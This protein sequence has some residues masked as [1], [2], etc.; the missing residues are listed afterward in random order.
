[1]GYGSSSWNDSILSKGYKYTFK[2]NDGFL[3]GSSSQAGL[4]AILNRYNSQ[5]A[6]RDSQIAQN[7]AIESSQVN[8]AFNAQQAQINRDWQTEMSN[9]AH[10]REVADLKAA[11]LN[12]VLSAGGSGASVGSSG[13]A[14]ADATG[15]TAYGNKATTMANNAV[16]LQQANLAADYQLKVAQINALSAQNVAT[17]NQDTQ[18]FVQLSTVNLQ[19]YLAKYNGDISKAVAEL[20][21]DASRYAADKGYSGSQLMAGASNYAAKM[22]YNASH[23]LAEANMYS[24]DKSYDANAARI[25]SSPMGYAMS[26]LNSILPPEKLGSTIASF[27]NGGQSIPE[28]YIN[29]DDYAK[30]NAP[31]GF[32]WF[33][34]KNK[35]VKITT[36][37]GGRGRNS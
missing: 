12:P 7:Q 10:Q 4:D 27:K 9:T 31:D 24:A 13:I 22:S 23:E 25:A 8:S 17:I 15:A 21:T 11:G 14:S 28:G 37:S 29:W 26:V 6:Y 3:H 34:N 20:Y 30:K 5:I 35:Y 1:M 2:D 19:K 33:S 32:M 36:P 18:K 16:Q